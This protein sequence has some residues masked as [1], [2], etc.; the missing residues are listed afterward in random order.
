MTQQSRLMQIIGSPVVSEK[1]TI[2]HEQ[3]NCIVFRVAPDATKLEI[4]QVVSM[5]TDAPVVKI[6]T[7]NV[8]GKLR[9]TRYGMGK[10]SDWKKVYVTFAKGANLDLTNPQV[11][12]EK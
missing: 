4:K 11:D 3:Q 5:I 10:R 7:A 2:V 1:A 12:E 8:A 6:H 9:R